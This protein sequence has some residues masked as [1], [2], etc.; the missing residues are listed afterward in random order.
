MR[1]DCSRMNGVES[2]AHEEV[3]KNT[4]YEHSEK[5]IWQKKKSDGAKLLTNRRIALNFRVDIQT[6]FGQIK[7]C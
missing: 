4:V 3:V 7:K 5:N 6:C 1:N 2:S